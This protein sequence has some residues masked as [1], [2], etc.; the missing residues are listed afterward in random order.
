MTTSLL[1]PDDL[2]RSAGDLYERVRAGGALPAVT[3]EA[4]RALATSGGGAVDPDVF[5][6]AELLAYVLAVVGAEAALPDAA[7]TERVAEAERRLR[8]EEAVR[9]LVGYRS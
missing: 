7:F 6:P 4:V 8:V 9:R 3:P 2:P 1:D 5:D